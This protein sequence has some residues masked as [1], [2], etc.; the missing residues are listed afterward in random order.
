MRTVVPFPILS[1]LP[2]LLRV[3]KCSSL[4]PNPLLPLS[5]TCYKSPSTSCHLMCVL[6]KRKK[7]KEYL[8]NVLSVLSSLC[9]RSPFPLQDLKSLGVLR[10]F[11]CVWISLPLYLFPSLSISNIFIFIR[12][13]L[14]SRSSG[15]LFYFRSMNIRSSCSGC[16]F[17]KPIPTLPH[18]IPFPL[19]QMIRTTS[20][21]GTWQVFRY[22][23]W[24]HL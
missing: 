22:I 3:M 6:V 18:L 20:G 2:V 19:A 4:S 15:S 11:V 24:D 8:H 12:F 10:V 7:K 13:I 17:L 14:F 16:L 9:Y 21:Q 23:S 1:P 5:E